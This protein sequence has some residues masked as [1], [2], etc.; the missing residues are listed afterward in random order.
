ATCVFPARSQAV[1]QAADAQTAFNQALGLLRSG[2]TADAL[3]VIDRAIKDGA[4]DP[5]LYNLKGLAAG[6]LGHNQ[7]AEESFRTV[8]ELAPKAAMGY[9]NLGVL[10][11][12]LE[13][14]QEAATAFREAHA[15]EPQNFNALLGLGTSLAALQ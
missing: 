11:S 6:E 10:L 1:P 5:A 14:Y 8:I 4:R 13:R 3:S 12:K 15:N 2:K 7:E 9:N